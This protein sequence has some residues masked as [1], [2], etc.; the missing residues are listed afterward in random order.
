ML[1]VRMRL[2]NKSISLNTWLIWNLKLESEDVLFKT[3]PESGDKT[4]V[5]LMKKRDIKNND[6]TQ[7]L[8]EDIL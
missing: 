4:T 6:F 2:E 1:L 7:S 3:S 8:N 5:R